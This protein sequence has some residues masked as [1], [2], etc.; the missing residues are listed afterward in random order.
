MA[1]PPVSVGAVNETVAAPFSTVADGDVGEPGTVDGVIG[2]ASVAVET[3][4][5]FSATAEKLYAT[6]FVRPATVH[7][8]EG[9]IT[10]HVPALCPVAT[11]I[12]VTVKLVGSPPVPAPVPSSIVTEPLVAVSVSTGASG[13][14]GIQ[15]AKSDVF[16][17]GVIVSPGSNSM[18]PVD[19][20]SNTKR[21]LAMVVTSATVTSV[22]GATISVAGAIPEVAPAIEYVTPMSAPLHCAVKVTPLAGI[23]YVEPAATV[24]LPSLQPRKLTV[25]SE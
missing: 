12:A 21:V 3:P 4:E 17:I 6:P 5:E 23:V 7:E 24:L 15:T 20:V 22:L 13:A 25:G 10:V 18:L 11:L 1:E 19:H 2:P 16:T 14:S 8:V 9:E